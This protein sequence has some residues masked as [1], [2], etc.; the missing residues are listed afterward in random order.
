MTGSGKF[1]E[2]IIPWGHFLCG[3]NEAGSDLEV[4]YYSEHV[5]TRALTWWQLKEHHEATHKHILQRFRREECT[6]LKQKKRLNLQQ[7]FT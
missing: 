3:E 1:K 6:Y 4:R 2:N 7:H 5:T